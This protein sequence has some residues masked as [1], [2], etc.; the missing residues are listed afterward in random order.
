MA[1]PLSQFDPDNYASLLTRKCDA[2]TALLQP[3]TELSPSVFESAARHYRLRAEFRL[4]HHDEELSYALF[5]S[6]DPRTPIFIDTFPIACE[7]IDA[8]MIPLL[9]AI[10]ANPVLHRKLFQI[11]FLGTSTGEQLVTLV[12]HRQLEQDWIDAATKLEQAFSIG[13]IGRARKQRIVLSSESVTERL[14]VGGRSFNFVQPE[15]SFTQPNAGVNQQMIGW[16]LEKTNSSTGDL[17][18]LYCGIG[19][20]TIP[21][22]ANFDKV[23]ATEISKVSIR[24]AQENCLNNHVENI[25]VVR[26]S[27]E[28]T[29]SAL[30]N[31]RPFRR[32]AHLDLDNYEFSTVFVDPPRAGLD[33]AT[34]ALVSRFSN[35]VYVS[36]NPATLASNLSRLCKS[37]EIEDWAI[38]DQF[39]YTDH[40]E[41]GVFLRRR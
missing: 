37:H 10:R 22:A 6:D 4:W 26:L 39:P 15:N 40:C 11:E 21:L 1:H 29:A 7:S 25:E 27:S 20:F 18:E 41:L 31:E 19:N 2:V 34:L 38:F 35:I 28:E 14:Q 5:D 8:L 30:Q 9:D 3:Y 12:Y 16:C 32:L 36:C 17:L 33:D 23:L 13:I 24:A